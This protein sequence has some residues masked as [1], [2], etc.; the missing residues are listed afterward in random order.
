MKPATRMLVT[1]TGVKAARFGEGT[2]GPGAGSVEMLTGELL[3][4]L[5]FTYEKVYRTQPWVYVCVNK[6]A[7]SIARLPLKAYSYLDDRQAARERVKDHPLVD[8]LERPWAR[9][10]G[11]DMRLF[12]GVSLFIY[13]NALLVKVRDGRQQGVTGLL[14]IPWRRIEVAHED[15]IPV[16]YFF[17]P[18]D[19]FGDPLFIDPDDAVHLR[20][21][22]SVDGVGVSPLEPLRRTLMV[23]DAAS[24]WTA[25]SF[26]QA[27][28][29]S[30]VFTTDKKLTPASAGRI[31][32]A[33]ENLYGGVENA[34]RFAILDSGL[35]YRGMSQ[36]AADTAVIDHRKLTREEVAAVFDIPPPMVGILDRATFSNIETQQRMWY[37]DTLGAPLALIEQAFQ[38]Q[39]VEPAFGSDVFLEFDLA[40]VLKGDMDKRS[41]A[42]QRLI[43]SGVLTINEA[44][45]R[46][47]LPP[48]DDPNADSPLLPLNMLPV[49]LVPD[50]AEVELEDDEALPTS[51]GLESLPPSER[52][53]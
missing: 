20:Y 6:L 45:A 51:E 21:F 4:R 1:P 11:F 50:E 12:V 15:G 38:T 9:G 7:R 32:D 13:G 31:R 27:A 34:G 33:L 28:T 10:S 18:A 41:K 29:P 49:D 46:E 47:N 24:G 44:R 5:A 23:E 42:Y 2:S 30:G 19:N 37:M 25:Q 36:T 48:V 43:L 53:G 52:P 17:H 3:G 22:D 26:K 40:D 14:P 8:V 39:L 35:E 16:G